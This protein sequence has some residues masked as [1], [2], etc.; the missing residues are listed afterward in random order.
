MKLPTLLSAD[1]FVA[2]IEK[3]DAAGVE[4]RTVRG[5]VLLRGRTIECSVR[6]LYVTFEGE[7]DFSDSAVEGSFDLTGCTFA[8]TLSLRS[9]SIDG[10]LVLSDV[11]IK[12]LPSMTGRRMPGVPALELSGASIKGDLDL[13]LVR[14]SGSIEAAGIQIEGNLIAVGSDVESIFDFHNSDI[15]GDVQI[16]SLFHWS[17]EVSQLIALGHFSG[18]IRGDNSRI[19]G[20]V[21]LVAPQVVGAVELWGCR[22]ESSLLASNGVHERREGQEPR[23]VR[24]V[25]EGDLNLVASVIRGHVELRGTS[26]R[27]QLLM[28]SCD[29]GNVNLSPLRHSGLGAE[30][31]PTSVGRM[32][33][34]GARIRGTVDL[35]MVR[36]TGAVSEGGLRGLLIRDSQITRGITLWGLQGSEM[37]AAIEPSECR[38]NV[39]GDLEVRGCTLGAELVFT[40]VVIDGAIRLNDSRITGDVGFRSRASL[41]DDLSTP[42]WLRSF[43]ARTDGDV[44]ARADSLDLT[45]MRCE[46]DLDLTGLT[47]GPGSPR[48]EPAGWIQAQRAEVSGEI[49]LYRRTELDSRR[50]EDFTTVPGRADFSDVKASSFVVSAHSF[51]QESAGPEDVARCGLSLSSAKLGELKVFSVPRQRRSLLDLLRSRPP[52]R[53]PVPVDLGDVSVGIWSVGDPAASRIQRFKAL[54]DCDKRFRRTTYI[55]IEQSLRNSGHESDAVSIYRAMMVAA[56]RQEWRDAS[57]GWLAPFRWVRLALTGLFLNQPYRHL[58]GFGTRPLR[59]LAVIGLLWLAMM[60]A[61][62]V[63]QNFEPTLQKLASFS[64]SSAGTPHLRP[65]AVHWTGSTGFFASVAYHLPIL[66]ARARDEWQLRDAG[67]MCWGSSTSDGAIEAEATDVDCPGSTLPWWTPEDWGIVMTAVNWA[68]WPLVL[69]F[70][71]RKLLR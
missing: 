6:A 17:D 13:Q 43:L 51:D 44:Q 32:I 59:L 12:N 37:A 9:C 39:L 7:V 48:A 50:V 52:Y 45:M 4:G 11:S 25:I 14:V 67:R 69:T 56:R 40:N 36:V 10:P 41:L 21:R 54:L 62:G 68:L 53:F 33:V 70:T 19:R 23:I 46:N 71:V 15:A 47:L 26:I 31:E 65:E 18:G 29:T 49:R 20:A 2:A 38:A 27:G 61:Y 58:M 63:R 16:G 60:P 1:D 64:R 55:A 8:K 28:A 35:T 5:P 24:T 22:L 30:V 42:A 66:G 57:R 34:F 3:G